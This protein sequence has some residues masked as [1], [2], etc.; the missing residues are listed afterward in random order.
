MSKTSAALK[1]AF[2]QNS[3]LKSI[4]LVLPMLFLTA[5]IMS[6]GG[7]IPKN[8]LHLI[9]FVTVY[10]LFNGMFFLMIYTGKTDRYRAILFTTLAA[11]MVISFISNMIEIR[12]SMALT[13]EDMI[14]GNTPFCHMVIPMILIPAAL[15]KTIIFPGSILEGF[16]N[17]ATMFVIWIGA[18]LALGRGFCSWGC[19]FGGLE[20]GFSRLRRKPILKHIPLKWS[21][22]PYAV[23]AAV[24][25]TS[26][27]A[28]SPTYCEWLCPFKAVTEF[29]EITSFKVLVQTIIFVSLF[30]GLVVV[31]PILTKRRTQCAFLCPLG[32]LQS[33][34]NKLNVFEIRIDREK[35]VGCMLC[36][37]ACPTFSLDVKSI[38]KGRT[39][40]SCTKCGK[41]V[42]VCPKNAIYFHVKGTP[43]SSGHNKSRLLFIYP[44]LIF[45][46]TFG[47]GAIKGALH[48]ILLL[49]TTGSMIQ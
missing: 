16:A 22:M 34:T 15:T 1:Q 21:Y 46:A 19:F 44:A 2:P 36:A 37:K 49:V 6:E 39:R 23:L 8:P 48:R 42:D 47:R 17:V 27:L 4:L 14:S 32:A 9:P 29:V 35:C 38:A 25:L 12:G 33:F 40:L 11:S 3:L 13:G 26:T 10:I 7:K 43:V 20:E 5:M 18:S 45:L 31:L 41:C 24:V 30:V 28:L